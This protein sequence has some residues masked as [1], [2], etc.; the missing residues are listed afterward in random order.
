MAPVPL[1][2]I[3]LLLPGCAVNLQEVRDFAAESAKL[4]AASDMSTRFRA[5]YQR[6]KPYHTPAA[7]PLAKAND[8]RRQ[9]AYD[10]IGSCQERCR[11]TSS[12]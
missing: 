9:R 3:A 11:V 2:C 10:D 6:E 5:T 8:A 4:S 12:R 7:D 1:H